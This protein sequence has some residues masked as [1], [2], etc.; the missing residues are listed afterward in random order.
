[1][2]VSLGHSQA[3]RSRLLSGLSLLLRGWSLL[4]RGRSLLVTDAGE[5]QLCGECL[6]RGCRR[7]WRGVA[8]RGRLCAGGERL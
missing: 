3:R 8:L 5:E 7:Q 4:L 6:Q 1:M 2:L